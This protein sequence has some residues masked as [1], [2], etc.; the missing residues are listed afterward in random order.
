MTFGRYKNKSL[1]WIKQYDSEYL[2]W[3]K[4]N[5]YVQANMTKLKEELATL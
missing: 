3:L 4:K 2:G 1:K 5:E